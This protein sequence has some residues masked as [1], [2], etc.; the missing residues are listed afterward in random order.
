MC[1]NGTKQVAGAMRAVQMFAIHKDPRHI[2]L[3]GYCSR[4]GV[5]CLLQI[6][7]LLSHTLVDDIVINIVL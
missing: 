1:A 4:L 6:V 5:G 2:S 7:A 3:P